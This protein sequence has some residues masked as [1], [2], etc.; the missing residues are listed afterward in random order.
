MDIPRAPVNKK[1]RRTL[2]AVGGVA[3]V[4]LV[5]VALSRLRPAA[6]SVDRATL[7][8]DT[9]KQ[10]AM[11]RDVRGPGTLTP[12]SPTFISAVTSG[13]VDRVYL[14]PGAK[15]QASTVLLEMSNPDVELQALSADQAVSAAQG[16]LVTLRTSL[17]NQR[18][19]QEGVV[20]QAR[21]AFLDAQRTAMAAESLAQRGLIASFDLSKARDQVGVARSQVDIEQRR[22]AVIAGS[23]DSQIALQR[24]QVE[25]LRAISR[26]QQGRIA[27]MHV[28]AGAAGV[29]QDLNLEAGQWVQAGQQLAEVVEPSRLK[30]VLRVAETQAAEVAPL[31]Q[32]AIDTRNGIVPGHVVRMDP[33]AQ[34]GTVAVDVAFDGPLPQGS[35][36]D[37]SVEGT[38]TIERLTN[39]T[40]VGRP[41]YGQANSTVGLFKLVEGGGYAVRVNVQLGR[42]SVNSVEV[43]SGL[44]P[45]DVVILSDMSRYDAVDRVK[46]D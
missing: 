12:E 19:T 39:V 41:A 20:A 18:L 46:L 16:A 42:T 29:L 21:S 26:F 1:R 40:Y 34:N 11:V 27:S 10:G 30:A 35:R 7:V 28:T 24:D 13:R 45:G 31:Q 3:A 4:A 37:L 14:R 5:T 33:S 2:Y 38:I 32:A 36:S 25:R 8:I 22:L 9:V 17:E 15:V 6:P 23:V 43:L 44:K